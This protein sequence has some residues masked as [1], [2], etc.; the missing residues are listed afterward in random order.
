MDFINTLT[1]KGLEAAQKA[2]ETAE[3]F[4]WHTKIS[5]EQ[6]NIKKAYE[7]IGR[8]FCAMNP[9]SP[10][11][12][13]FDFYARIDES[14]Q[15]IE[16]YKKEIAKIKSSGCCKKCGAPLDKDAK[17]CSVCGAFQEDEAKAESSESV[18]C[19]HCGAAIDADSI[20][21]PHCGKN[22]K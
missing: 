16:Q 22:I 12:E 10:S 14:K 9:E 20:H 6:D 5:T 1:A 21:C 11:E 17:Y 4:K 8:L 13:Y 19:P 7:D 3:L 15:L 18:I 2:K